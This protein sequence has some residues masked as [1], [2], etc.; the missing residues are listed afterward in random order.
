MEPLEPVTGHLEHSSGRTGTNNID[1]TEEFRAG[2]GLCTTQ[3]MEEE[4]GRGTK[5]TS[6]LY[7]EG[8]DGP[9]GEREWS[10]NPRVVLSFGPLVLGGGSISC[11]VGECGGLLVLRC[12]RVNDC[13]VDV[14]CIRPLKILDVGADCGVCICSTDFELLAEVCLLDAGIELL[15]Q[16]VELITNR[17]VSGVADTSVECTA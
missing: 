14:E 11:Q 10:G 9:L 15:D 7:D 6:G 1:I 4:E 16:Q 8:N 13:D 5:A 12:S 3:G 2:E 17:V